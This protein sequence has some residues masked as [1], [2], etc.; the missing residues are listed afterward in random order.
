MTKASGHFPAYIAQARELH[1]E[2]V[3]FDSHVDILPSF[4]TDTA[5]SDTD[6]VSQFDLAKAARGGLGGVAL[7]VA[8]GAGQPTQPERTRTYEVAEQKFS[9]IENFLARFPERVGLALGPDDFVSIAG[10][11]KLA[12]VLGFQNALPFGEDVSQLD[13]WAA[14]GIRQF[15]F[16]FIGNNAWS[17][18]ARPYPY[19]GQG[20]QS[21]GL[22]EVGRE[23]VRRLNEL[24]VIVDVSQ[25]SAESLRDILSETRAPVIASHSAPRAIVD[26]DRNL[27]DHELRAIAKNG[28]V[29]QVVAFG[30]YVKPLSTEMRAKVSGLWREY[31]LAEPKDLSSALSINDEETRDWAKDVYEEFLHEFHVALQLEDPAATVE[32]LVDAIEHTVHIAGIDHVGISSDFNHSGGVLGWMNS[33]ETVNVT[34]ELLR[35]GY[36][37]QQIAKLWGGNYLRAWREIRS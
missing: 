26:V 20:L 25:V 9:L 18:S 29:V 27:S 11:G 2:I 10:G 8:A 5:D 7:T 37:K 3:V 36:S 13:N 17:D 28:G 6:G 12:V 22:S 19:I 16:N 35:R 33:G 1:R 31:G 21:A 32:D 30:P 15:G 24:G 23:A 34:A 14:R 4:A